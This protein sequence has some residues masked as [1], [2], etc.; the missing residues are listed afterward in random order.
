MSGREQFAVE[1]RGTLAEADEEFGRT[2]DPMD[3]LGWIALAAKAGAPLPSRIGQWLHTALQAYVNGDASMDEAM[4]LAT[5]GQGQPRRKRRAASELNDTLGR[6][7][8]LVQAGATRNQAAALVE[9]T[10]G[11]SVEQLMRSY[12]AS[13]FT[14]R[15][16][17]PFEGM[18]LSSVRDFVTE[19]LLSQYPDD[20]RTREAK[21][22]I[23][24]RYPAPGPTEVKSRF[25]GWVEV[26]PDSTAF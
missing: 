24:A 9:T 18:P 5:R 3:A 26:D 2:G 13:W 11:R 22:A 25:A 19:T 14:G 15:T 1:L 4:G 20:E 12:G 7:W 10:T 6:M 21:A 16:D 23:L 17:N 8:F